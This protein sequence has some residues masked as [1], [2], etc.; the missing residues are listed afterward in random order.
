MNNNLRI[1]TE[2]HMEGQRV[3]LVIVEINPD[4]IWKESLED[5]VIDIVA[6]IE[7]KFKGQGVNDSP[8]YKDIEKVIQYINGW[9]VNTK[10]YLAFIQE[11]YFIKDEITSW[12][13]DEQINSSKGKLVELYSYWDNETDESEWIVKEY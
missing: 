8:F 11:K 3:D 7:M 9:G 13:S 10:H 2:F 5:C 6:T 1:F 4:L 12:L